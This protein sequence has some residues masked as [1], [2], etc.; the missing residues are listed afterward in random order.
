MKTKYVRPA[1]L[2]AA[3]FFTAACAKSGREPE[4]P[5]NPA[6]MWNRGVL[7]QPNPPKTTNSAKAVKAGPKRHIRSGRHWTLYP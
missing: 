2:V 4:I 3:L 6:L 1:L 7:A 5:R